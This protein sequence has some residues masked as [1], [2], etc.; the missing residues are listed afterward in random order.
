VFDRAVAHTYIRELQVHLDRKYVPVFTPDTV[1][2]VGDFGS[3]EDGRF[4]R[5]G[6]VADRGL[7]LDILETRV[8]AQTFASTGKVTISP[9]ASVQVGD[10]KLL[11]ATLKFSKSKAIVTAFRRGVDQG[12]RDADRFADQLTALWTSK[13]LRTDRCVVWHVR[14]AHGGTVIVSQD[15]DNSVALTADPTALGVPAINF[16]NLALHVELGASTKAV[17]TIPPQ[18]GD[19]VVSMGLYRWGGRE[20]EDAFGFITRSPVATTGRPALVEADDL[21]AQLM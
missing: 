4:I 8:A 13:D 15:G 7:E 21:L 1:I 12:V 17:W 6:N 18:D 14:R 11:E 2:E 19:L 5:K 9:S 16:G 3:L 20:A 10:Q